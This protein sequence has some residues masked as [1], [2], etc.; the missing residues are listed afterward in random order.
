MDLTVTAHVSERG[1]G[2]ADALVLG[3]RPL[4]HGLKRQATSRFGDDIWDLTPAVLQD[5]GA[6]ISLRFPSLP[7]VYQPVTKDLF[8]AL[9]TRENTTPRIPEAVMGPLLVWAVRFIADF[10]GDILAGLAEWRALH[11]R[12]HCRVPA[13]GRGARARLAALLD[14]YWAAGRPLPGGTSG[15]RGINMRHLAREIACSQRTVLVAGA[16]QLIEEA[17]NESVSPMPSTCGPPS[18]APSTAATGK[19]AWTS[20]RWRTSSGCCTLPPT[21]SSPTC[22]AC[23]TARSSTCAAAA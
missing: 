2:R 6:R 22:P 5:H 20:G 13:D 7:A 3:R 21:S 12:Q 9:L 14:R 8:Y 18:T 4:Q 10:S 15:H 19:T 23:A 17:A 11:T 16:F 1:Q